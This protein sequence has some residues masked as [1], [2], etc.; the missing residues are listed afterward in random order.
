MPAAEIRQT[1]SA[2][3][4][5]H[6]LVRI[7]LTAPCDGIVLTAP[8]DGIVVGNQTVQKALEGYAALEDYLSERGEVL[9]G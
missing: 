2:L 5:L 8:C 1:G 4:S 9:N 7:G 3:L 6:R